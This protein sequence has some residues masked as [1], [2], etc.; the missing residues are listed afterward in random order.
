[1]CDMVHATVVVLYNYA[2]LFCVSQWV[3]ER[4]KSWIFFCSAISPYIATSVRMFSVVAACMEF[5][6][7]QVWS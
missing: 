2:L 7:Q 6:S 5:M 4:M 1:M 3:V